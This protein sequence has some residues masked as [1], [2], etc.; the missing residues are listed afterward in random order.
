M[1]HFKISSENIWHQINDE[2]KDSGGVY[3][4]K[5]LNGDNNY[6]LTVNRLLASDEQGILYIGKA[7]RFIDRVAELKKSISPQYTS[8]SHECGSRYK[9]NENIYKN[10]PYESLHVELVGSDNPRQTES[11]LLQKYESKYG[12]LPPLN[13]CS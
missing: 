5:C 8:G 9:S 12:E 4:L 6:P 10:F 1:K 2:F 7:N 3:I 13:R 11:D